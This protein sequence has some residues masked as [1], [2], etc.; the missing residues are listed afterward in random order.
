[1]VA[2]SAADGR[3]CARGGR[4]RRWW[5]DLGGDEHIRPKTSIFDRLA[6]KRRPRP[7]ASRASPRAH[8]YGARYLRRLSRETLI[9]LSIWLVRKMCPWIG[10]SVGARF[11]YPKHCE[12]HIFAFGWCCWRQS[13]NAVERNEYLKA[14]YTEKQEEV[15]VD[16]FCQIHQLALECG[17]EETDLEYYAVYQICKDDYSREFF[18]NM[19]TPEG[20][21]AFLKRYCR[22][23]NLD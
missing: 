14:A 23:H 6:W 19:T 3:I 13:K 2:G 15:S 16:F 5:P 7:V 9:C 11:S 20:R 17:V 21:L 8:H 18:V 1:V 12:S 22:Q 10:C 4:I